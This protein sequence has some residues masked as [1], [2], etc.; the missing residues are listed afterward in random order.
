MPNVKHPNLFQNVRDIHE[1]LALYG[2]GLMM[3][4]VGALHLFALQMMMKEPGIELTT[5]NHL[6]IIR[7][8]YCGAYLGIA[9][10]FLLGAIKPGFSRFSLV[11]I[12]LLFSGFALGRI[13]SI[14]V[15]GLP[16]P[17]YSGVLSAEVFF[18]VLAVLSLRKSSS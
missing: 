7:A 15:D 11:A 4:V 2:A 14:V 17:L 16:A 8:A 18:T 9:T 12:A 1:K 6:H 5:I 10:L 13:F 3:L